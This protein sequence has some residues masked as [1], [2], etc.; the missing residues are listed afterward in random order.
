MKKSTLIAL[1]FFGTIFVAGPV[2]AQFAVTTYHYDALRTG[3]N[4]HETILTATSF[5][6]SFGMLKTVPLDDQV[7]AQPL[8]VPGLTITAGP[9]AGS[10]HDVVY[11]ATESNTIYAIDASSG[12][13]LLSPKLGS[14]VPTPL[15]CL[16]NGPNVGIT[17]T[18]VIDL[19]SH[20]LFVIAY[21]AG[22][23]PIYQLHALNLSDLTDKTGS[24]VTVAAS[25]KLTDGST[26]TFD[27]TFAR[28]CSN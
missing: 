19:T 8:L 4:N 3:W 9:F 18:P 16:N 21:V 6:G 7:D 17:G 20:T 15:G 13:I 27:A 11:V 14:P 22:S 25:H 12:D 2:A 26:L 28:R 24:P 10:T 23:P 1:V 5:P